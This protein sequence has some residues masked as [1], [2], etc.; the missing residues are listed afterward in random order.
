MAQNIPIVNAAGTVL[1]TENTAGIIPTPVRFKE[2][3]IAWALATGFPP[4][5]FDMTGYSA[6]TV[7]IINTVNPSQIKVES[8]NDGLSWG[9]LQMYCLTGKPG[10][11][12]ISG[13]FTL[14]NETY[15]SNRGG[16][17]VRITHLNNSALSDIAVSMFNGSINNLSVNTDLQNAYSWQYAST[18]PITDTNPVLLIVAPVGQQ[19]AMLNAIASLEISNESTSVDTVVTIRVTT[20][21]TILFSIFIPAKGNFRADFKPLIKATA[22]KALEVLCSV[23]ASVRVN[24]R[25]LQLIA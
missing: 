5:I 24:V 4:L 14:S 16:R 1:S 17:F 12:S 13:F 10:I 6:F 11:P 18:T 9:N 19:T 8:S 20:D 21:N 3:S 22:G 25:G 2:R 23:A 7:T 15:G